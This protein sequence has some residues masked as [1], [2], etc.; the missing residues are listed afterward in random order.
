MVFSAAQVAQA[1]AM[2]GAPLV[3]RRLGLSRGVA[4]MQLATALSLGVFAP[5]NTAIFASIIYAAY[6]SFQYMSEPG[7]YASLMNSVDPGQRSG[8]SALNFLVFFG[9][10]AIAASAA[11][12]FVTWYGYPPLLAGAAIL[13]GVAAWLFSRLKYD[14]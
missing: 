14:S 12:T 4:A 1:V 8:A 3:L 7:I 9:G 6:L 13:A 11:G 5:A 10:Q 2:F